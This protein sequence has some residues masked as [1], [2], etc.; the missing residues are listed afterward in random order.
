M[1]KN[2][3]RSYKN[4]GLWDQ[5]FIACSPGFRGHQRRIIYNYANPNLHFLAQSTNLSGT[6][7][8]RVSDTMINCRTGALLKEHK[9]GAAFNLNNDAQ[10]S[11]RYHTDTML[12]AV[13]CERITISA[14][15]AQTA[16]GFDNYIITRSNFNTI[17]PTTTTNWY[18]RIPSYSGPNFGYVPVGGASYTSVTGSTV[19]YDNRWFHVAA[20]YNGSVLKMYVNGKEDGTQA[21]STVMSNGTIGISL[22]GGWNATNGFGGYLDDVCVWKRA[23]KDDEIVK[24]ASRR[25]IVYE[26]FM[27]GMPSVPQVPPVAYTSPKLFKCFIKDIC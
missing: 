23:L 20:T 2:A 25:G 18:F 12:G 10:L 27:R 17:D 13:F 19:F 21:A 6:G 22:L 7:T 11:S 15:V 14:W 3:L 5:C 16:L 1:Y 24:L 26:S 4:T 8:N 9:G